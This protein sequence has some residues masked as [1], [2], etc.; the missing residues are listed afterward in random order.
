MGRDGI[1]KGVVR[2]WN[3][4]K[5]GKVEEEEEDRGGGGGGGGGGSKRGKMNVNA[6][7]LREGRRGK[8][9]EREK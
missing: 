7:E 1:R 3:E 5:R 4:V 2:I 9:R 8:G 6:H